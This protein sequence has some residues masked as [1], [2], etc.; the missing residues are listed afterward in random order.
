MAEL[1]SI[2]ELALVGLALVSSQFGGFEH[3]KHS[4]VICD[5][6]LL[7][8]R[9]SLRHGLTEKRLRS[10]AVLKLCRFLYV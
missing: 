5:S 3:K 2:T 10:P 9:D 7:R 4:Y 6:V 1:R 8:E